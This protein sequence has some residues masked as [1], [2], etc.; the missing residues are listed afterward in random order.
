MLPDYEK[1]IKS[2]SFFSPNGNFNILCI[3]EKSVLLQIWSADGAKML[4]EI[5]LR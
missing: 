5:T 1:S 2:A 4:S 3:N